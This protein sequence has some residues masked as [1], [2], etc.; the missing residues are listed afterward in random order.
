MPYAI[1][2]TQIYRRA[3]KRVTADDG[4]ELTRGWDVAALQIGLNSH[5]STKLVVDGVYGKA[6]EAAVRSEQEQHKLTVDGICGQAT[7][8]AICLFEANRAE[9]G[10]GLPGG[11]LRG[12]IE[13]ESG[14]YFATT[15][16]LYVRNNTRDLG[17]VQRNTPMGD[18]ALIHSAFAVRTQIDRTAKDLRLKHDEFFGRPGCKTHRAA[19]ENAVLFHNWQSAAYQI[20]AGTFDTWR[21]IAA[22]RNGVKR[23]YHVDEPAD[24]IIDIGVEGVE[25][26]REWVGFYVRTKTTYVKW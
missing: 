1:H 5:R 7:Q 11:M 17:V 14:F 10:H 6:S 26:A 19:W 16:G 12:L 21:Y 8:T 3:F 25:T 23:S 9:A 22:D 18:Q 13:G 4:R 15:T 2:P 24:W 20:A